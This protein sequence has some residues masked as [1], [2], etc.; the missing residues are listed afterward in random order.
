MSVIFAHGVYVC[1]YERGWYVVEATD[2]VALFY[3]L[4]DGADDNKHAQY[5][6]IVIYRTTSQTGVELLRTSLKQHRPNSAA[7]TWPL[8]SRYFHQFNSDHSAG[9][10]LKSRPYWRRSL[11]IRL[12]VVDFDKKYF[13]TSVEGS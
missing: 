10:R 8:I 13:D 4:A 6:V 9:L 5:Y 2:W 11:R 12:F 1:E 7:A 3:R